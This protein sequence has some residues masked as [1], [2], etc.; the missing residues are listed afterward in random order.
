MVSTILKTLSRNSG[1]RKRESKK[2]NEKS[3]RNFSPLRFHITLWTSLFRLHM[4]LRTNIFNLPLMASDKAISNLQASQPQTLILTYLMVLNYLPWS[5]VLIII[6]ILYLIIFALRLNLHFPFSTPYWL[7]NYGIR[8]FTSIVIILCCAPNRQ[9]FLGWL[10]GWFDRGTT[11]HGYFLS[12]KR[13]L[14][15]MV[16]VINS[17]LL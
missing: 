5:H 2:E 13:N 17:E 16:N 12:I 6:L 7:I 9:K 3:N 15:Y 10:L 4:T 1:T 14:P 8:Y 11:S